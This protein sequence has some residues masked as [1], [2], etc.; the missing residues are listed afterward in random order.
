MKLALLGDIALFGNLSYKNNPDLDAYFSAVAD[1][2]ATMDYVVGNLETPFSVKKKPNGAKSAYICSDVENVKA[3]KQLHVNAVTLAN[4]HVFDYGKEGYELTKNLLDENGIEFFGSEGKELFKE[5]EGNK[6]AFSGFCCYSTNPLQCV[7]YGEYGVNE[8]NVRNA[9]DILLRNQSNGFLNVVAVHA[10]TEHVNYPSLDTI[11]VAHRL[12]AKCPMIYYGHHPHVSQGV[13]RMDQS[14]VAYSLGNFCFD[15]VYSS[16]SE[17]PLIELSENNRS[18]FILEVTIEDNSIVSYKIVPIYIGK[19]KM[20]I[21]DKGTSE[22][23]IDE[24]TDAIQQMPREKYAVN[25]QMSINSYIGQRKAKR[26]VMW[27]LKRLR[28][29]YV[30]ILLNAKRNA[31]KYNQ[32]VKKYLLE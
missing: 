11:D 1:Y 21:G 28:P 32:S 25:R 18:S 3:L 26:D 9:E 13:E 4:N 6:L 15:D 17:K 10:G 19:D 24:Y 29:R 22:E 23:K 2:L 7:K 20:S 16:A 31:K 12:S 27:Y 14:L 30:S 8:F 5:I